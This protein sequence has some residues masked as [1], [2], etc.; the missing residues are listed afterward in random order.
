LVEAGG[1][2]TGSLAASQPFVLSCGGAEV[3]YDGWYDPTGNH[4]SYPPGPSLAV[5]PLEFVA[6]GSLC[7]VSLRSGV[8]TDKDGDD[9]PGDHLGPY[10][11]GI[12][13]MSIAETDPADATDGVETTA[14]ISIA[15]NAP[16]D[17]DSAADQIV[18]S[19]GETVVE[20]TLDYPIDPKTGDPTDDTIAVATPAAPLAAGTTYTVT[21][22][23]DSSITDIADGPLTTGVTFSFTTA[24]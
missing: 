10:P 24:E 11:F 17:L 3:E 14:A 15:F 21:V 20:V 12:A 1:V 22:A 9:F 2:I 19:A 16:V 8:V 4:L 18:V 6:T 13:P 7:E 5:Q 23:E